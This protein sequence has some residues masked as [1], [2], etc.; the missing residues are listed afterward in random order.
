M[1][2]KA[3]K[4]SMTRDEFLNKWGPAIVGRKGF[5][6]DLDLVMRN[7][8]DHGIRIAA[9]VA[10]DYDKYNS[11]PYL[12]SECILGKLNVLRRRPRKNPASK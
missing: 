3:I 10:A 2:N 11:H 9:E 5:A 4:V 6:M 12:V 8:R 1:K 7:G